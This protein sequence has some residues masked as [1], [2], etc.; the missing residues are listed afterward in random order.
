M[1]YTRSLSIM[2]H[3]CDSQNV[4]RRY[5]CH[6]PYIV[7][8]KCHV[9]VSIDSYLVI[10]STRRRVDA[11]FDTAEEPRDFLL[12]AACCNFLSTASALRESRWQGTESLSGQL[13]LRLP[14]RAYMHTRSQEHTG[15]P[16]LKTKR[17]WIESHGATDFVTETDCTVVT[18]LCCA[19][20]LLGLNVSMTFFDLRNK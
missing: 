19:V 14:T 16:T 6:T 7:V 12:H 3:C 13:F 10:N 11:I 8:C 2:D 9:T 18:V 1:P 17:L 5:P 20:S 15:A 4:I